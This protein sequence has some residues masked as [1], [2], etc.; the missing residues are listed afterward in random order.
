MND[1]FNYFPRKEWWET[2]A[3]AAEEH[4]TEYFVGTLCGDHWEWGANG[5][6]E[7]LV[8]A[9]KAPQ[10]AISIE[11]Q[12]LG[13]IMLKDQCWGIKTV[14][15]DRSWLPLEIRKIWEKGVAE[16]LK[17]PVMNS[18]AQKICVSMRGMSRL[19]WV[20]HIKPITRENC[21]ADNGAILRRAARRKQKYLIN[22]CGLSPSDFASVGLGWPGEL[23]AKHYNPEIGRR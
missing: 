3:K 13:G 4:D 20:H 1:Y 22:A 19:K 16:L 11:K 15:Y 6:I 9:L 8:M 12:A 5:V 21:L 7:L 10:T 17:D 2:L 23:N 14:L 18:A